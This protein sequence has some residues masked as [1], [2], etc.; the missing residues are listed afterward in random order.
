MSEANHP[1]AEIVAIALRKIRKVANT[2]KFAKLSEDCKVFLDDIQRIIPPPGQKQEPAMTGTPTSTRAAA[3]SSP[4]MPASS[5]PKKTAGSAEQTSNTVAQNPAALETSNQ[6]GGSG[7]PR[8]ARAGTGPDSPR[9]LSTAA[10]EDNSITAVSEAASTQSPA[11]DTSGLPAL[12]VLAKAGNSEP[13]S[14]PPSPL[15]SGFKPQGSIEQAD[16]AQASQLNQTPSLEA[17]AVSF[18]DLVPRSET[19]L[20][21]AASLKIVA[22]M[23]LAVESQK[24]EV[25][26]VALDCLQKLIAFR[27]LQ[28]SVYA[29]TM[30]STGKDPETG[31]QMQARATYDLDAHV[32]QVDIAEGLSRVV[33]HVCVM[34]ECQHD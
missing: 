28:G 27:F 7:S 12:S 1:A 8:S 5:S 15:K 17:V 2:R 16:D 21:D 25:I 6:S 18:P 14:Q 26:E 32:L 29:I 10:A 30:P 4:F 11:L 34:C 3:S 22:I 9:H 13:T 20:S 33:F 24:P 19:A 31:G 23:R